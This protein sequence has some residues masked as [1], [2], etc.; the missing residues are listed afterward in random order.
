MPVVVVPD[1]LYINVTAGVL[2]SIGKTT[3]APSDIQNQVI[4]AINQYNNTYLNN[5]DITF[6]YSKLSAYIDE[7]NDASILSVNLN[8]QMELRFYP[9]INQA[10]AFSLNYNNP[11]VS[12]SVIS[13]GFTYNNTVCFLNDDG[14]G[15]IDLSTLISGN[16]TIVLNNVG[17]INY[18]T[19]AAIINLPAITAYNN[20]IALYADS[21]SHD[22][23][24]KNNTIL[25]IDPA[26]VNVSVTA[27]A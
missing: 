18:T 22:F 6:R 9:T 4:N 1:Y 10:Q 7:A 26:D 27:T 19:G 8:A 16:Q 23:T 20:K 17:T 25:L 2:Y 5:F 24:V 3:L 11:V 21:V 15:N 14:N 12:G 13:N